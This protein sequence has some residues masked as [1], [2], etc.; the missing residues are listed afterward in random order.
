MDKSETLERIAHLRARR[1]YPALL[2]RFDSELLPLAKRLGVV[3]SDATAATLFRDFAGVACDDDASYEQGPK[4]VATFRVQVVGMYLHLAAFPIEDSERAPELQEVVLL[5]ADELPAAMGYL[6]AIDDARQ[7]TV[8]RGANGRRNVGEQTREKA[9]R[10]AEPHR[11]RMSRDAAAALV[12]EAIHKS[13]SYVRR[14]LSQ[15]FPGGAWDS[16]G[17]D[18]STDSAS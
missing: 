5:A 2:H 4:G 13:P 8:K 18:V 14:L 9:R 10:A 11:G 6:H 7:A 16:R 1:E 15:E 17:C 3:G 12:A